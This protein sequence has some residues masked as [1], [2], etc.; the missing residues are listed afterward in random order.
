[1]L[2]ALKASGAI[3]EL[4][5]IVVTALTEHTIN[6]RGGLPDGVTVLH[7]PLRFAQLRRHLGQLVEHWQRRAAG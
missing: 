7:K 5:V 1:M 2:R 6:E 3:C 4:E